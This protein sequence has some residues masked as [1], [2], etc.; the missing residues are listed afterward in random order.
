VKAAMETAMSHATNQRQQATEIATGN[1]QTDEAEAEVVADLALDTLILTDVTLARDPD[2][3]LNRGLNT[4][5]TML[6]ISHHRIEAIV[7]ASEI[8]DPLRIGTT[9]RVRETIIRLLMTGGIH[10]WLL[11]TLPISRIIRKMIFTISLRSLIF[12]RP[13]FRSTMLKIKMFV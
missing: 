3:D 10:V 11:R 13:R 5:D 4:P 12:R 2:L 9:H 1:R 7:I 6:D 8:I